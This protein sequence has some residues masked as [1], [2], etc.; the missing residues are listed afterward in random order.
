[1]PAAAVAVPSWRFVASDEAKRNCPP[2]VSSR[3][4]SSVTSPADAVT[5]KDEARLRNTA[6]LG[7][8]KP[9]VWPWSSPRVVKVPSE[10]RLSARRPGVPLHQAEAVD[11]NHGQVVGRGLKDFAIV[12][13]LHEFV[14]VGR[15]APR[16]CDWRRFERLAQMCEDLPDRP[17]LRDKGNEP[18]VAAAGWAL[19]RKLLPHPGHQFRP[20]NPGGVVRAEL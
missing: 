13:G 5:S 3:T 7:L 2:P 12:V 20:G 18:D 15:R 14:P 17:R 6:R 19:E 10:S 11:V 16:G 1:M 4:N 8:S 9:I